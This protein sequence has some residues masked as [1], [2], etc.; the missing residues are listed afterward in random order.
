MTRTLVFAVAA[1]LAFGGPVRAQ[2]DKYHVTPEEQ[3]ACEGD[4]TLLCSHTYPDED[5][6]IDCMRR[7]RAHLT[8]VCRTTFEAG[9]KRRHLLE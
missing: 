1:L 4:A 5:R 8:A 6:L 3:A 7:N 9:L 2:V